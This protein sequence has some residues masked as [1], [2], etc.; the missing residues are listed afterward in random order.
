MTEEKQS[1][2]SE[3][4]VYI[5]GV[6]KILDQK[7]QYLETIVS[8]PVSQGKKHFEPNDDVATFFKSAATAFYTEVCCLIV[9]HLHNKQ[10]NRFTDLSIISDW[11]EMLES[12]EY[13]N[14][15]TIRDQFA[16]H[17]DSSNSNNSYSLSRSVGEIDFKRIEELKNLFNKIVIKFKLVEHRNGRTYAD[18]ALSDL[19]ANVAAKRVLK[20]VAPKTTDAVVI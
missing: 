1:E 20:C 3:L 6:L 11:S 7:I 2:L 5:M 10:A 13:K 19:N 17:Q 16:G 14:V 12:A 8:Y 18:A 9:N 4:R 15:K